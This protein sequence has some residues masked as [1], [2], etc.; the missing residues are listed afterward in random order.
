MDIIKEIET[1]INYER[2][3]KAEKLIKHLKKEKALFFYYYAEIFRIKGLIKK[4]IFYYEK[5]IRVINDKNKKFDA[6]LKLIS[7][8]RTIGNVKKARLY[9]T[10]AQKMNPNSLELMIEKAMYLRL[11]ERYREAINTFNKLIKYYSKY[12]DFQALSYIYWAVGGIYRNN[13]DLKNSIKSFQKAIK[14]SNLVKDKSMKLYSMLGLAGVLRISGDIKTSYKLYHLA[15][16]MADRTD[17]FARAY[18]FCGTANALRQMGK[19]NNA[20]RYYKIALKLYQK[21]KDNP[22]TALVLWGMAE[23]Y[24]KIDITKSLQFINR[25]KKLLKN[26]HEIRGSI[27]LKKIEAEIKYVLGKKKEA[28]RI[29][30]SAY[31]L[32]KKYKFNTLFETFS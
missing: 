24:K 4:S 16:K 18:S 13:G 30:D 22:D 5:T 26:S 17:L 8:Y 3:E 28:Q 1:H 29:F 32:A 23:C 11:V 10:I 31:K 27:L 20:L 2:V 25:A 9:L 19:I 6:L 7:L 14:Y 15:T 21:I 12:K